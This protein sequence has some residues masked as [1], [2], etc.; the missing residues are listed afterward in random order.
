MIQRR[1]DEWE[2]LDEWDELAQRSALKVHGHALP[3][4]EQRGVGLA[5]VGADLECLGGQLFGP[6]RVPGDLSSP[7]A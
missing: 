3:I 7:G 1:D 6:I 4:E 5:P 2:E